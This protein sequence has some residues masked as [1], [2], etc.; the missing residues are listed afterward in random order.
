M[1]NANQEWIETKKR[2]ISLEG[3]IALLAFAVA[4]LVRAGL[5]KHLPW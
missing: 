4:A 1:N 5:F 3:W 2:A